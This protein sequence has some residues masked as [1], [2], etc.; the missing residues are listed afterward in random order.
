MY[1]PDNLNE[2][3]QALEDAIFFLDNVADDRSNADHVDCD[4][5]IEV[6]SQ[7]KLELSLSEGFNS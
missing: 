5:T 2:I 1:I 3:L 4:K 6:L 7:L